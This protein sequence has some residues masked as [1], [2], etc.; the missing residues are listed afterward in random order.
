MFLYVQHRL[1]KKRGEIKAVARF[2]NAC[3]SYCKVP[4]WSCGGTAWA[5]GVFQGPQ[6]KQRGWLQPR[7]QLRDGSVNGD[8]Y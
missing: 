2:A 1:E 3:I 7:L 8:I 4:I 5:F 6:D